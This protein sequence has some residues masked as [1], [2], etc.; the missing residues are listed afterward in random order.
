[1]G[2]LLGVEAALIV[3]NVWRMP[4]ALRLGHEGGFPTFLH[5]GVLFTVA[6]VY[7]TVYAAGRRARR[8]GDTGLR[9]P[10]LWFLGGFGFV[11][12]G[13]DE[14]LQFHERGSARVFEALGIDDRIARYELTPALWEVIFGPLFALIGVIVLG[15][16]FLE[17]RRVRSALPIA[18]AAMAIWALAL[19]IEFVE[20]TYFIDEEFW[21]GAA[22]WLE[23]TSELVGSTVFLIASLVAA[24]RLGA[25]RAS[26]ASASAVQIAP[27]PPS[28]RG[29]VLE[30]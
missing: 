10:S 6:A 4:G 5:T 3:A 7:W 30:P 23:E 9:R 19:A 29:E 22:I 18:L 26:S 12:L 25:L 28:V 13:L 15:A 21:F 20:T 17:R 2:L 11:Y 24:M 27:A 1:M 8:R 16:I 14:L